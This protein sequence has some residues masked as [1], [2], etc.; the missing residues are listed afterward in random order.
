MLARWLCWFRPNTSLQ[1]LSFREGWQLKPHSFWHVS[2]WST[3]RTCIRLSDIKW[4]V[5]NCSFSN[6]KT[7]IQARGDLGNS[8]LRNVRAE[9]RAL[10]SYRPVEVLTR[11][12]KYLGSI[13]GSAKSEMWSC[14]CQA[15]WSL[16]DTRSWQLGT[17]L[18]STAKHTDTTQPA[19][20]MLLH[21]QEQSTN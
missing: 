4:K 15:I 3:A 14:H 17:N 5:N 13:T 6:E 2:S 18:Q 1:C 9:C 20:D 11:A 19:P 7:R 21:Q 8:W 16:I 10:K 12:S